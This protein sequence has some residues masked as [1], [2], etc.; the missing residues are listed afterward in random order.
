MVAQ[1]LGLWKDLFG[2]PGPPPSASAPSAP[3]RSTAVCGHAD[4]DV[5][6]EPVGKPSRSAAHVVAT[7][8]CVLAP[9]DHLSWVVRKVTGTAADPHVHWT[10]RWDLD[11][12][13]GRYTYDAVLRTTDPGSKREVSVVLMDGGTYRNVKQTRDPQTNYVAMPSPA[14]VV[15]NSVL[16]TTPR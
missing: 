1:Y 6:L 16:I 8:S 3:A 13:P 2:H 7:V 9:G 14:P 10:L 5:V 12:G 4:G 15:S 11:E